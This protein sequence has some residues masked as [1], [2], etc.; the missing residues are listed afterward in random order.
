[1]N[2]LSTEVTLERKICEGVIAAELE[3]RYTKDQ[4]LEFYMNSVFYGANAYGVKAAAQEY[5]HK[6]LSQL[7]VAEAATIVVPIRNP[8]FYNIRQEPS[9]CSGGQRR[10][11]QHGRRRFHHRGRGGRGQGHRPRARAAPRIRRRQSLSSSPPRAAPQRHP[12]HLGDIYAERKQALYGCRA[13][14][15][16]RTGGGGLRVTITADKAWDDEATR[17]C[18]PGSRI[19][20]AP[21]APSPPSTTAPGHSG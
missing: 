12:I 16:E 20:P 3:R 5:F 11:R 4:I 9:A 15:T 17:T 13:N 7:T 14:Y 10:H 6:P 19:S 2:S 8:S 18:G 1:M 21:P